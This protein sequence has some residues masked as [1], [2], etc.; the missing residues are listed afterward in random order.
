MNY[1]YDGK[2][3]VNILIVGRMGCGKTIFVQNLGK[4]KLFGDIDKVFWISKVELS[5]DR[6]DNI[7]DCFVDQTVYFFYP[8]NVEEFDNLLEYFTP[9]KADYDENNLGEKMILDKVIVMDNVSG[10]ADK[11][12]EFPNFLAVS[13]KCGL[14]YVYIFHSIHPT[15]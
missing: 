2:F 6:E 15:R 3:E 7:R 1:A 13:R 11:S 12:D 14:T 8:N 10:L 9:K 4:N 5:K